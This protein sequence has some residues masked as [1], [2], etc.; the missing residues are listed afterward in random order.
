MD[1]VAET[2]DAEVLFKIYHDRIYRSIVRIVKDPAEAENLPQ[3]TILRAYRGGGS[4][5]DP[6]S[7]SSP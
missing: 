4:L 2:V 7:S 5:R 3:E 1:A 6:M